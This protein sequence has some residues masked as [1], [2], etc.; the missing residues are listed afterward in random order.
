[1]SCLYVMCFLFFFLVVRNKPSIRVTLKCTAPYQTC[2]KGV[3]SHATAEGQSRQYC[4]DK[5]TCRV[6]RPTL[7]GLCCKVNVVRFVKGQRSKD[8]ALLQD[9]NQRTG[10]LSLQTLLACIFTPVKAVLL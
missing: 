4:G 2:T 3:A 8:T 6:H 7:R 1:M 10:S 9:R 5:V